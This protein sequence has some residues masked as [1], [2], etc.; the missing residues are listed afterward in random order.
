MHTIPMNDADLAMIIEAVGEFCDQMEDNINGMDE[1]EAAQAQ[2]VIDQLN[3]I[4]SQLD[5]IAQGD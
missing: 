5:A 3:R 4:L 1:E 2:P